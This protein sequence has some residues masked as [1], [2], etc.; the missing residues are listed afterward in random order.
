MYVH[1]NVRR[2]L[3]FELVAL[4]QTMRSSENYSRINATSVLFNKILLMK[5][6]E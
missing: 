5:S 2:I 4:T 1:Y 6:Y 3:V